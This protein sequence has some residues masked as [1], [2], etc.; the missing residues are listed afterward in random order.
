MLHK[1]GK[2]MLCPKN[3]SFEYGFSLLINKPGS[4]NVKGITINVQDGYASDNCGGGKF[5]VLLPFVIKPYMKGDFIERLG[6]KITPSKC[7]LTGDV[8]SVT[9]ET[10]I[11]A[12]ISQS[13]NW[14]ADV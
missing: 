10:G 8:F 6:K 12:F 2:V 11:A 14:S 7:R 4:Y 5:P 9:D 13:K 3:N 1:N